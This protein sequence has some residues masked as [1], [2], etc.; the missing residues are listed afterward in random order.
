MI[1]VIVLGAVLILTGWSFI[2]PVLGGTSE[3]GADGG[4][5][6]EGGEGEGEGNEGEAEAEG[7]ESESEAEAEAES[8][9]ESESEAEAEAEAESESESEEELDVDHDFIPDEDEP[10]H[11]TDQFDWDSDDDHLGDGAEMGS[12][13]PNIMDTDDD[14]L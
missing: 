1:L 13:D 8:E 12:T 7:S 9:A 6:P 5:P 11:F 10:S 3:G 4:D 14:G 2:G